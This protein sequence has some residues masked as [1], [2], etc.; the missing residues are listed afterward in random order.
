MALF[1]RSQLQQRRIQKSAGYIKTASARLLDEARKFDPD[2][3][4]HVFLSHASLDADDVL[5][6]KEEIEEL[7]YS[8]YV[9]WIEDAQ[10]DRRKVTARNAAI[11]KERMNACRSLFYAVTSSSHKSV[12]MPW[13]LGYFDGKG[14]PVAILP[15]LE[16]EPDVEDSYQGQEY[17]GLYPYVS[18]NPFSSSPTTSRLQATKDL[19]IN[20]SPEIYVDMRSWLSGK[21]P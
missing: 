15:V 5:R 1:T 2:E 3:V 14:G 13:E 21:K 4:Y 16:E 18:L 8:V 7:G 20:K 11:L 12:W 19:F 9:D 17:L 6:L 10:L